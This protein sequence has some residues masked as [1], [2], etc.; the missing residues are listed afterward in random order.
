MLHFVQ[1]H[2]AAPN[3]FLTF[4]HRKFCTPPPSLWVCVDE[5]SAEAG[6]GCGASQRQ[7]Q[8]AGVCHVT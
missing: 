4:L 8:A 1:P 2:R 3:T 7:R 5:H 6:D